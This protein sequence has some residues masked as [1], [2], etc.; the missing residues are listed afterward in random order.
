[1]QTCHVP[2]PGAATATLLPLRHLEFT[3]LV[4]S[5]SLLSSLTFIKV[6]SPATV[7]ALLSD[8]YKGDLSNNADVI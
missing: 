2:E 1:M 8:P 6:T 3:V 5:F 4:P 7:P